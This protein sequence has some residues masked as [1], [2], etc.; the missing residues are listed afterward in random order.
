MKKTIITLTLL[1]FWGCSGSQSSNTATVST[2]S[3]PT[4]TATPTITVTPSASPKSNSNGNLFI[5]P[6]IFNAKIKPTPSSVPDGTTPLT[7]KTPVKAP[8]GYMIID[9]VLITDEE[10]LKMA[11]KISAERERLNLSDLEAFGLVEKMWK[12]FLDKKR[13]DQTRR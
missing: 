1:V 5:D 3:T 4:P 10:N 11:R 8:P 13:K 12:E 9:G 7:S 6:K 2:K